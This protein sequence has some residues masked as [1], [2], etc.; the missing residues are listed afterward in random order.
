MT[1]SPAR[2]AEGSHEGVGVDPSAL[3]NLSIRELVHQLAA[4]EDALRDAQPRVTE[5]ATRPAP[6][7]HPV[8]LRQRALVRE[9]RL[10]RL[11]L[12]RRAGSADRGV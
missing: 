1:M 4:T 9:L 11:A 5:G 6:D 2:I 12:R 10:R 8:L 7:R 3:R